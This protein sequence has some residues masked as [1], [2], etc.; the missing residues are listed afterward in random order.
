MF[1]Q[2]PYVICGRILSQLAYPRWVITKKQTQR[3]YHVKSGGWQCKV[4]L[5]LFPP[6]VPNREVGAEL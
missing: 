5:S 2:Y 1:H 4:D 3:E 6:R